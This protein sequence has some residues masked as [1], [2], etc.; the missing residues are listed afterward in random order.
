MRAMC[1]P[2]LTLPMGATS[3]LGPATRQFGS[4][5]R[6]L[7]LQSASLWRGMLTMYALLPTLLMDNTS[8]PDPATGP[9][10]SGMPK[11][12]LLSAARYKAVLTMC[13][14]MLTPPMT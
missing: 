2:L 5:M 14:Q 7:V 11:L 12:V 13:D 10:E 4:G 1:G 6:R 3:S 9:F 8:S